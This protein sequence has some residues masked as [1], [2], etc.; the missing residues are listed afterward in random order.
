MTFLDLPEMR[1][2]SA[3]YHLKSVETGEIRVTAEI[4]LLRVEATEKLLG[5]HGFLPPG[6][7]P[8]TH[9][10]DLKKDL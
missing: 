5:F 7:L 4:C 1:G 6:I 9:V 10:E 2:P 8:R 3:N